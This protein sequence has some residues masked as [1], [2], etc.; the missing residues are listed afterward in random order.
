MTMRNAA[1]SILTGL[2]L[3][4]F[5]AMP[6]LAL[7]AIEDHQDLEGPFPDG[8]SVTATCLECHEDA[9]HDFMKTSHWTWE[10]M[11]DVIGKGQVPLG[12]KNTLNNFCIAVNSNW[13]R[14]TSCHAGYGWKD[15]SFDF[16]DATKVDC[17]VCHDQTGKYRKF[18]TGAGHPVYEPTEWNG[19]IWEPLDLAGLAR[20]VGSPQRHNCGACHF[21]GGGGDNVKHG[22]LDNSLLEPELSLD[23]HMSPDGQNFSCQECHTTEAHDISGNS[24]FVSP[25]GANHLECTSCHDTDVH[26]KRILNWHGKSV[27]CQT[28][29]VPTYA[30]KDPTKM[31]WDWSTAGTGQEAAKDEFGKPTFDNKKGTFTW[32]MNVVPTY[33]W[34]DGLSGQY[35]LGDPIN[36]DG[37][38]K[39][40]HPLGDRL[41][42]KSKLYP[43][44]VMKGKQ[45]YDKGLNIIA[46]PKL[47]GKT[48]FWKNGF[49]WNDALKQ[50]MES[51]GLEYSGEYGFAETEAWWRINHMVAPA[52]DALHCKACHA[53]DG[54][55]R[56][57][58]KALGYTGDPA[59]KRG[60]S[61]YE[62]HEAYD[63]VEVQ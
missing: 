48:G 63:D 1:H 53:S 38:T 54:S 15:G 23:V 32:A 27:A 49:E 24:M 6:V 26:K 31:W 44:K 60:I 21:N 8:P 45:P 59:H 39:L 62:L 47:F 61:R 7:D 28:C 12:K 37:V 4:L 30:R 41:D 35:L 51:V 22:D 55:G 2:A 36:P 56:L 18:P 46:V 42:P 13:P 3:A 33:A 17:L 58:W 5:C 9:A 16:T 19:K 10:P 57:D 14:C 52:T 29:H 43:F 11:Q 50:G 20:T 25:G 40:N 34:Y